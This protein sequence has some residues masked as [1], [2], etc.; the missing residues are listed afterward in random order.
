MRH[1]PGE[2]PAVRPAAGL[3]AAGARAAVRVAIG[4]LHAA[5][6]VAALVALTLLAACTEPRSTGP[7]EGQ[8]PAPGPTAA[9]GPS[10]TRPGP[11]AAGFVRTCESSVYGEL[12]DGWRRDSVIAGPLAFV[13]LREAARGPAGEFRRRGSGYPGQ[14]VLVVVEAGATVT[15]TVPAAERR[16]LALL[17]DPAS[18]NERNSYRI[19]DG[20]PAVTFQACPAEQQPAGADGTQFNGGFVVAG[21]RCATLEVSTPAAPTPRRVAVSFGAGRCRP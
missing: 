7:V 6:V 14:K 9:P 8:A 4:R 5:R 17:Y 13:A 18:W 19:A 15:V 1:R 11:T 12:G 20:Q 21:P 3:P 16:H 10:A 2:A